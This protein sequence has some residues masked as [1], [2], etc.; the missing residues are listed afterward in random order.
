MIKFINGVKVEEK[1]GRVICDFED[2]KAAREAKH[3]RWSEKSFCDWCD[4]HS[5]ETEG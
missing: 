1:D 2:Y 3:I 5:L 4:K